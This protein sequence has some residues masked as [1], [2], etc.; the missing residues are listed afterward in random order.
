[1]GFIDPAHEWDVYC[2][3]QEAAYRARIADMECGDCLK[4]KKTPDALSAWGWC[5]Y[6]EDY[7][8]LDDSVEDIGCEEFV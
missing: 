5:I 1:M 8:R 3:M 4:C 7:V 2:A 6:V